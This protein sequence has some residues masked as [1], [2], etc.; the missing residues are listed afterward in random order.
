MWPFEQKQRVERVEPTFDVRAASP[1][2]PT[3]SLSNPA[4]WLVSVMGG[5]PTQAGPVVNEQSAI[6]STT[7]FRC[8]SL[9][10]GLIAWLPMMVYHRS[11]SGRKV[12]DSHRLYPLLHD[13]PSDLMSGFIWREL[14]AV[15][16]L[17]GGNHY[18]LIEY[19]GAAR[20]V[21]FIAVPR[22]A[23][24]VE[25]IK[26]R[27]RYFVTYSDGVEDYDQSDMLHVPGLGFDGIRG[28]SP[29]A[30]VSRQ[31]IGLSLAMEEF[32]GRMHSN[33]ARPSGVVKG[34]EGL[35]KDVQAFRRLKAEFEAAYAGL[36]NAGKTIFLDKGMDWTPMQI[37]PQD[38]ETLE[39]RRFQ[40][41]DIARAF[42]VPPHMVGETDKSTSWG[43][44]IEQM[45]IGFLTFS[46]APWLS[47][48]EGE[49]NRKLFSG[50]PY[51]AEFN[52]D[53][54]LALDS[55]AQAALFASAIQ[56][57]WMKPSEVRR[58]KNLPA[59]TGADRLFIQS[60]LTPIAQAGTAPAK[61]PAPTT[62]PNPGE[63]D[64]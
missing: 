55:A 35:G 31:A 49:L 34:S 25:K 56:N 51:Y 37:S 63:P 15:D 62:D 12:A 43:S 14:M 8:V 6:R 4:D 60:N 46:L 30:A 64:Q 47:R 21:G 20:V 57:G 32:A 19:D 54:L 16:L 52:R 27:L 1:E 48:I 7:V 33:G 23:V 44:G 42:G 38:A 59:E 11:P 40:I 26:G 9:L 24:R 45:T 17:L 10:A 29:I 58:L 2:N 61:A 18:S 5:G 36:S 53:A 39:S 3:T 13:S 41:S 28:I 50:S 22:N